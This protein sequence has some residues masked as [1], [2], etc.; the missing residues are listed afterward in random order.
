MKQQHSALSQSTHAH[1]PQQAETKTQRLLADT[2]PGVSRRV[3]WIDGV[4]GYLLVDSDDV[5]I[6]QAIAGSPI[7]IGIVG[8]LGRQSCALR[9]SDGEYLLQ[10][11]QQTIVQ[12]DGCV[13]DRPQL[14]KHNAIVQIGNRVKLCFTKPNAL[15]ASARLDLVSL[16][17]FKPHVDAVLLLA[18]S[19]ILGPNPASHVVCSS[20]KTELLLFRHA[21]Q[22]H[23]RSLEEVDVNG[24]PA[25]GQIPMM[26]GM[27]MRGE[28]FSLSVE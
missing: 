17:R 25:R 3:L 27:R 7:D 12:L 9:R 24:E 19:C 20:W 16:N 5:M 1:S 21:G 10:P 4:G 15:S 22:W 23:F 13:I 6:G 28:D 18:D 2:S 11:L 26:P 14:L 8:D